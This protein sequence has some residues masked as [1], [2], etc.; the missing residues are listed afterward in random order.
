MGLTISL[1]F[2]LL[3][4]YPFWGDDQLN[5]CMGLTISLR[6]F[7]GYYTKLFFGLIPFY[8]NFELRNGRLI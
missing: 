7:V 2:L 5:Q 8:I 1:V 3:Y 6:F 4:I